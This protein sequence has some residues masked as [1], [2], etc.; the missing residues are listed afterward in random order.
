MP[1]SKK[2]KI[3]K[4]EKMRRRAKSHSQKLPSKPLGVGW[5]KDRSRALHRNLACPTK[6]VV[7]IEVDIVWQ[8]VL[9]MCE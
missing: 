5:T 2:Q 4:E 7:N 8:E 9:N 1:S 6:D 3:S